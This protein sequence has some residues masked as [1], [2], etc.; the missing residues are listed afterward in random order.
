[1]KL[2]PLLAG[3]PAAVWHV[4]VAQNTGDSPFPPIQSFLAT[5]S[6]IKKA[7]DQLRRDAMKGGAK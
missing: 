7:V 4:I 5:E 3:E 2:L 1:M 6:E